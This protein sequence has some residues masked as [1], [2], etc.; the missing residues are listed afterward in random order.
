MDAYTKNKM[1]ER[2]DEYIKDC[3]KELTQKKDNS[4]YEAAIIKGAAH[5]SAY[6]RISFVASL[7]RAL[8]AYQVKNTAEI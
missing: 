3:E 1:L 7:S 5:T 8:S 2:L 6:L 4:K